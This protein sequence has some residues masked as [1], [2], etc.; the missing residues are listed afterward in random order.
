MDNGTSATL[1]GRGYFNSSRKGKAMETIT[2]QEQVHAL[3]KSCLALQSQ[4][5][6]GLQ[7]NVLEA[8]A[9]L[10][11]VEG[12]LRLYQSTSASPQK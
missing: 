9:Q 11:A 1:A 8:A 2:A 5:P 7:R 4:L 12:Y 3:A 10:V 6:R